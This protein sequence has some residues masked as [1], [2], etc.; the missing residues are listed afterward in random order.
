MTD[1]KDSEFP[2]YKCHKMVKAALI[3]GLCKDE[4]DG[5]YDLTLFNVSI[6]FPSVLRIPANW[7]ERFKPEVGGYYVMYKDG[8]TSFSP[9][10]EFEDG[11]NIM[12]LMEFDQSDVEQLQEEAAKQFIKGQMPVEE[13][14]DIAIPADPWKLR[15]KGMSCATC[16]WSVM[17]EAIDP[18]RTPL[19]RCRKNAPTMDGYP[20]IFEDDWCGE[21]KLDENKI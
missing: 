19:G 3:L 8:Y 4:D 7:V 1:F 13:Y 15:S 9:K 17:K 11:Y 10:K 5:A 18:N 14:L 16:M 2:L 6:G 21:H 12:G 20:A